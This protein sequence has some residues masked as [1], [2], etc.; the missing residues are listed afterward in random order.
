LPNKVLVN[1]NRADRHLKT[2]RSKLTPPVILSEDEEELSKNLHTYMRKKPNIPASALLYH[3]VDTQQGII[4]WYVFIKFI[5]NNKEM[6]KERVYKEA[7]YE[8]EKFYFYNRDNDDG[9][10]MLCALRLWKYDFEVALEWIRD[11]L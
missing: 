9:Y 4:L 10:I 1:V 3:L 5:A 7:Y 6:V 11:E 8:V 2:F